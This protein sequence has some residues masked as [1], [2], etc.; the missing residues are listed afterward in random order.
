MKR[1]KGIV[2]VNESGL[3]A[4][5]LRQIRRYFNMWA[6]GNLYRK[7]Q[8]DKL[9]IK[10]LGSGANGEVFE[11]FGFAVKFFR[12]GSRDPYILEKLQGHPMF[13]K[14]YAYSKGEFMI[15]ERIC[16]ETC[17]EA[18]KLNKLNKSNIKRSWKDNVMS[19]FE[20]VKERNILCFDLHPGNVMLTNNGEFVIIDVGEFETDYNYRLSEERRLEDFL[21]D[22]KRAILLDK[23]SENEGKDEEV[24]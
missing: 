3:N 16:G 15:V 12:D 21:Y 7:K 22:M 23:W 17:D 19:C 10:K 4:R 2:E 24:A 13:P 6:W 1:V 9:G 18:Y 14:L 5:Q 20:F 11:I 8:M